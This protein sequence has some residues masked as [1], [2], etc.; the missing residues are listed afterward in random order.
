MNLFSIYMLIERFMSNKYN[1]AIVEMIYLSI[2]FIH[3]NKRNTFLLRFDLQDPSWTECVSGNHKIKI[4]Y[5]IMFIHRKGRKN[6]TFYEFITSNDQK[7]EYHKK[8]SF[9]IFSP[10]FYNLHA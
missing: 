5:S 4:K 2:D 1:S 10:F 6:A 3:H 7:E 9:Y 8:Y